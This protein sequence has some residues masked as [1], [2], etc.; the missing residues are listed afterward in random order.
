MIK[1]TSMTFGEWSQK[2]SLLCFNVKHLQNLST[3]ND[4]NMLVAVSRNDLLA[5]TPFRGSQ[6]IV[7]LPENLTALLECL[8]ANH[9]PHFNFAFG[10]DAAL[11]KH[12]WRT[13]YD[14]RGLFKGLEKPESRLV[15]FYLHLKGI[16]SAFLSSSKIQESSSV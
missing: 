1:P 5:L 11:V 12:R 2:K 9:A 14:T 6:N 3:Q 13:V 4:L 10:A 8:F 15:K 7:L 16:H